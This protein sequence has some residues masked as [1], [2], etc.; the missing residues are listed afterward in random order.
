MEKVKKFNEICENDNLKNEQTEIEL[1]QTISD[2]SHL[3]V[4]NRSAI[5][6]HVTQESKISS[7]PETW[8]VLNTNENR[9]VKEIQND[10]SINVERGVK[11]QDD[12]KNV[13]TAITLSE[14]NEKFS[15]QCP[16]PPYS[17]AFH[18]FRYTPNRYRLTRRIFPQKSKASL[19]R[20]DTIKE[21]SP[22][23][24]DASMSFDLFSNGTHL[25]HCFKPL[26]AFCDKRTESNFLSF[27][28]SEFLDRTDHIME[29]WR[30]LRK[31]GD[32][33]RSFTQPRKGSKFTKSAAN[34]MIKGLLNYAKKGLI[35]R[36]KSQSFGKKLEVFDA[37]DTDEV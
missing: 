14:F 2:F 20:I 22:I 15:T 5:T 4:F 31:E 16:F 21:D 23:V 7:Y 36:D 13:A 27:R 9:E 35:A 37:A 18:Y 30:L 26:P 6:K 19:L 11:V 25:R 24:F 28:I 1:F 8:T 32:D 10:L 34:I 33:A 17:F 12:S 3:E 29:E